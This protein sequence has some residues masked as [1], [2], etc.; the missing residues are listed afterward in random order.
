MQSAS[1]LLAV[2]SPIDYGVVAF[3]LAAML[4][5]GCY[6]AGG[7]NDPTSHF[8]AGR[9]LGWLPLGLSQAAFLAAALA[10]S[11]LVPAAY[12]VGL[13]T[14]IIPAA[15]WLILPIV[16]FLVI[17]IY[18]GLGLTSIFGYLECRF[19]ARLRRTVSTLFLIWRLAW[20]V[21][22]FSLGCQAIAMAC[23]MTVPVWAIVAAMGAFATAYT[24]LGGQRAVVWNGVM[25]CGLMLAGTVVVVVAIWLS[26]SGGPAHVSWIAENLGRRTASQTEFFW[27]DPWTIWAALPH[28]L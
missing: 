2:L 25:Q 1:T 16:L 12:G 10:L 20:L 5:V 23:G 4:A 21:A 19:D 28:W 26:L 9:S 22:L 8:L 3:C 13:K 11:G 14:W 18:R 17:P 7:Q 15:F 24:A 27:S 6:F